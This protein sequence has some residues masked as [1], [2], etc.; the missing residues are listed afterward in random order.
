MSIYFSRNV[1]KSDKKIHIQFSVPKCA[2]TLRLYTTNI[3]F[4]NSSIKIGSTS[5]FSSSDKHQPHHLLACHT[6]GINASFI[7]FKCF[8]FFQFEYAKPKV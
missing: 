8:S 2:N 7:F 6:T 3:Q 5:F 4:Y 1:P